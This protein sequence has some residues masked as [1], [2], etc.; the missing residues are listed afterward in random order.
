VRLDLDGI[1]PG[2]AYRLAATIDIDAPATTVWNE[3]IGLR[4][5]S[6][7]KSFLLT[8][9][10]HLPAVLARREHPLS[11]QETFLDETPIPV[12][13][14]DEPTQIVLGGPSQPW[15]FFGGPTPPVLNLEELREWHDTGWITV[16]MSFDLGGHPESGATTL[17]TET[18]IGIPDAQTARAFD[19][20]WWAIKGGSALIRREVLAAVKSRAERRAPICATEKR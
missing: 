10:R 11:R 3:L 14:V 8:S 19:P 17:S 16:A 4:L 13:F 1:V 2:P 9:L 15:K 7:P 18:R 12:L 6:L 5:S 20:Y